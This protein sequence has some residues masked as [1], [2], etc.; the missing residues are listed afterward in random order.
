LILST[1][2]ELNGGDPWIICGALG[3]LFTLRVAHVELGLRQPKALGPGRI[4]GFFGTLGY[5]ISMSA[6]CG[7]L[8]RGFWGFN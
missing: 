8:T 1:I 2:A 3:A 7:W 5:L 6:Y 4:I